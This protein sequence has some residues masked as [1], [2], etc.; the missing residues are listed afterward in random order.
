M[1][2]VTYLPKGGHQ[3]ILTSNR[4]EAPQR[5]S[6][7]LASEVHSGHSLLFPRDASAGGTWIAASAEGRVVCMLNGAFE[8]H[9][10]QPPYRRSRGLMALDYFHFPAV[11]A[12]LRQYTF[13]GMEAFT[14]LIFEAGRVLDVRWDHT[15]LYQQ[16]LDPSQPHIWSSAPLYP[17]PVRRK[18]ELWFRQWLQQQDYSRQAILNWHYTAG[19]GD[20]WND[21][22]MNRDGL[23]RTLSISSIERGREQ[24]KFEYRDLLS[25]DTE[26][27][28][29]DLTAADI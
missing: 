26:Q 19:D 9:H 14:M 7:E 20:V 24:L 15:Q 2:T 4:D 5:N 13:A 11:E 17:A 25:G 3:F 28:Q 21:V 1:C 8:P 6:R 10:R 12:F 18:R 29:L 16:E 23:V 22:V 27:Q